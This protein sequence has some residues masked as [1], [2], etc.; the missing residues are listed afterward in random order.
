MGCKRV[1]CWTF[2]NEIKENLLQYNC[3]LACGPYMNDNKPSA[4]D[5]QDPSRDSE[6]G[7][8]Q[9]CA[10]AWQGGKGKARGI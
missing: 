6:G 2:V 8:A 7:E 5:E 10:I 3:V 1:I 9:S 4:N